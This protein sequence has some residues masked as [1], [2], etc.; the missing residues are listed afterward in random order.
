M[1]PEWRLF[2]SI[3]AHK[4]SYTYPGAD[5][6]ALDQASLILASGWTGV[7][8]PNGAGKSTLLQILCGLIEPEERSVSP[9]LYSSFCALL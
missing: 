6:S 8:R 2:M 1:P 7:I 4:L 5:S 3:T 9:R